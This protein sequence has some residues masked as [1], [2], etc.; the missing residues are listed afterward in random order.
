[1]ENKEVFDSL[2]LLAK[3]EHQKKSCEKGLKKLETRA[4]LCY[5]STEKFYSHFEWLSFRVEVLKQ[6][7]SRCMACGV[8]S[9]EAILN[10]D[11]INPRSKFPELSFDVDNMQILCSVCNIG[12]M[13][14]KTLF[15]EEADDKLPSLKDMPPFLPD[16]SEAVNLLRRAALF[17]R[18]GISELPQNQRTALT[19]CGFSKSRRTDLQF[20]LYCFVGAI[21]RA[22][23]TCRNIEEA[24]KLNA[25]NDKNFISLIS[26]S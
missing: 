10:V 14:K 22:E 6:F 24:K 25:N 1:M 26:G 23:N 12:K 4:M 9:K 17:L 20:K 11:H 21:Q 15:K 18:N 8:T 16:V 3:S 5:A 7:G 19:M 13:T 2:K